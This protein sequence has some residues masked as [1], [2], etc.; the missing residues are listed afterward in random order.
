[1]GLVRT[2]GNL[3]PISAA[4]SVL[5]GL[6]VSGGD[7]A[8]SGTPPLFWMNWE[9]L[10]HPSRM[11][12]DGL[13]GVNGFLV[14]PYGTSL[15]TSTGDKAINKLSTVTVSIIKDTQNPG[16]LNAQF[17]LANPVQVGPILSGR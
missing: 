11:H 10:F 9:Y 4:F 3:G 16:N 17:Q 2:N 14:D 12:E 6:A 7:Y 15:T 5:P 1:V 8:Y 13:S